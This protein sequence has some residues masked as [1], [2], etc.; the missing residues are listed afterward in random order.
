MSKLKFQHNICIR[1]DIEN[2]WFNPYVTEYS[3]SRLIHHKH[4][5]KKT[6]VEP[7][8][9]CLQERNRTFYISNE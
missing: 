1:N 9:T 4:V 2:I 3:L 5:P 6:I 8:H 7:S